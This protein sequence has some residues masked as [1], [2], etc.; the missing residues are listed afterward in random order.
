[1]TKDSEKVFANDLVKDKD[2]GYY[3]AVNTYP[4]R[5]PP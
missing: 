1:M 5:P 3:N 2:T 4:E